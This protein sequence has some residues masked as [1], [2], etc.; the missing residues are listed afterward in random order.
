MNTTHRLAVSVSVVFWLCGVSGV[1]PAAA[2]TFRIE[3]DYMGIGPNED[4]DQ[5]PCQGVLADTHDHQPSQLVLD[6]V[7]QMFACQGHTLIIDLNTANNVIPHW[8]VLAADPNADCGNFFTYQ[9]KAVPNTFAKFKAANFDHAGDPEPWHYCIFGH[10]QEVSD[11]DAEPTCIPTGS[12]GRADGGQNFVVTLGG[13]GPDNTGSEY[14][15]AATIAHEFGHNL[16]LSHC[17]IMNCANSSDPD[18][19]GPFVPNMPSTM[20]YRYQLFGLKTRML[21]FGL[22]FDEALFKELD[23]SHGR[24]CGLNELDLDEVR[25]T[26]MMSVDWDCFGGLENSVIQDINGGGSGWCDADFK[27]T[28]QWD[29]PEWSNLVDGA[30]LVQR[31]RPEDLLELERR[32]AN[33]VPC[34]DVAEWE[35]ISNELGLRGGGPTLEI[36]PCISGKN[37]YIGPTPF[38]SLGTCLQAFTSVQTAHDSS[39]SNSVFYLVPGTYDEVGSVVLN[40]RGKYFCKTGAAEIR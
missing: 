10:R 18:Y 13:K 27:Y 7:I 14:F 32:K 25:G 22:T 6:A 11:G 36:E 30:V 40:K 26:T 35:E 28:W 39:P 37:V 16:G 31:G 1:R 38:E 12:S 19:V 24:M 5:D 34:I 17:G 29:Y 23:Y 4:P 15:Q 21:F 2:D 3:I 9:S 20:S 33:Q 8:C